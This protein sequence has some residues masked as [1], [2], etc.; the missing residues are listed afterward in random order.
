MRDKT[1]ELGVFTIGIGIIFGALT[2]YVAMISQS[3]SGN[4]TAFAVV[5]GLIPSSIFVLAGIYL[6]VIRSKMSVKFTKW[7]V[8]LAFVADALL[9]LNPIK[10][11]VSAACLYLVWKTAGQ[12]IEQLNRGGEVAE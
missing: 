7:I 10:W 3:P 1:R 2:V 11:V 9:S 4:A 8:T 12:A 6:L 5:V